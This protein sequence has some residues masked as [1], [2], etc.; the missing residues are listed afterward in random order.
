MLV[1]IRA[2]ILPRASSAFLFSLGDNILKL[3]C[4]FHQHNY[5]I[6]GEKKS[7]FFLGLKRMSSGA[8]SSQNEEKIVFAQTSC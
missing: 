1:W 2:N 3:G 4:C 8:S 7:F 6:Q 5:L